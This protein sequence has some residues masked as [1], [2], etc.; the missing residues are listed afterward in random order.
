MNEMND[1]AVRDRIRAAL[2]P[3]ETAASGREGS[4]WERVASEGEALRARRQRTRRMISASAATGAIVVGTVV[5]IAAVS[6]G[7]RDQ[8][9][10]SAT[11]QSTST[12]PSTQPASFAVEGVPNPPGVRGKCLRVARGDV[13]REACISLPGTSVW[14]VDDEDLL[15][16]VAALGLANGDVVG[17]GPSGFVVVPF[18]T[19]RNQLRAFDRNCLSAELSD[20]VSTALGTA[21][22]PFT[23][24]SCTDQYAFVNPEYSEAGREDEA[25][26]FEDG[27]GW[28]LLAAID[29]SD[30]DRESR[31]RE[32][33]AAAPAPGALSARELCLTLG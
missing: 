16:A 21:A 15:I 14:R 17:A 19:Y 12:E 7:D 26:V 8:L 10:V 30:P 1:Q 32:L 33:P 3:A 13:S 4:T 27:G 2:R 5:G 6:R 28:A 11:D 18:D 25:L 24:S 29:F 9:S 22:P 31:C 20:A 23:V